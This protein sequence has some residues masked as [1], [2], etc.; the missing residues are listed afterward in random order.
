MLGVQ[1]TGNSNS[2][3]AWWL[4]MRK[5]AAGRGRCWWRRRPSNGASIRRAARRRAA[6][7]STRRANRSLGYGALAGLAN[8]TP[9]A[10]PPLKDPKDF[11]LIGRSL[12]RLDTPDKV[13]GKEIYG[14]DVILPGMK[15]ATI[16]ASPTF[17]AQG[18]ACRRERHESDPRRA[19]GRGAGRHGRG[20]RRSYVGRQAGAGGAEH[21]LESGAER[22][23]DSAQVWREIKAASDQPGLVAKKVGDADA[24]LGRGEK[25]ERRYEMPFLAHA[26]MEPMN[27]TVKLSPDGCE[28][29][30]GTQIAARVQS[31]VA[32][33]ANLPVDK[34]IVHNQ[35]IGG[36]LGR[37]LE[38]DM[39]AKAVRVAMKTAPGVPLKVV[40]TRDGRHPARCLSGPCTTTG[41][42]PR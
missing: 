18:R 15:F 41:S 22:H 31:T 24:A 23:V 16:A 12:K 33:T 3:R 10:N 30:L 19:A 17:G 37:R 27:C 11:R 29:W 39:A 35:L 4:P 7:C 5:A 8:G 13:N 28:V 42:A 40:W 6:W 2:I 1:A 14:I 20:G 26:T 32:A 25:F 38:P 34:V 9:P 36:G 21:Y